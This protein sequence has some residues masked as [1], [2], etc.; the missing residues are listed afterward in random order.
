MS[1]QRTV[2]PSAEMAHG[3]R[4]RFGTGTSFSSSR[5]NASWTNHVGERTSPFAFD[6]GPT[7][8]TSASSWNAAIV[9]VWDRGLAAGLA[10][11]SEV[12]ES[13]ATLGSGRGDGAALKQAPTRAA[14]AISVPSVRSSL[15][16]GGWDMRWL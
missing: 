3:S 6:N 9:S 7:A 1:S 2:R 14:R 10:G 4:A 8:G 12:A 5:Y 13:T 15:A 16:R 11:V